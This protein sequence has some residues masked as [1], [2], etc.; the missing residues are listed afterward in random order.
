MEGGQGAELARGVALSA[1]GEPEDFVLFPSDVGDEVP[2]VILGR[3]TKRYIPLN[4]VEH[5]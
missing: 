4:V 1:D 2:A 5:L 3:G